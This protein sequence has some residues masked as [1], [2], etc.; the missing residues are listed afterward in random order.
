MSARLVIE[1]VVLRV[2]RRTSHLRRL[3]VDSLRPVLFGVRLA[4]LL[5]RFLAWLLR[6]TSHLLGSVMRI[7]RQGLNELVVL[8]NLLLVVLHLLQLEVDRASCI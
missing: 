8:M 1:G 5:Q 3:H 2:D 6:K 7:A 4:G